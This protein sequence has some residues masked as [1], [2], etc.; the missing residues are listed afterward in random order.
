M[1]EDCL[2]ETPDPSTLA[3]NIM[4]WSFLRVGRNKNVVFD[5]IEWTNPDSPG[6]Y[7]AYTL[8]RLDSALGD[9]TVA[10]VGIQDSDVP[11]LA[12]CS[13]L[14]YYEQRAVETMDPAPIA[15]YLHELA[16]KITSFYHAERIQGGRPGRQ[17][18]MRN[19]HATMIR[20]FYLLGLRPLTR[21]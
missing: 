14:D 4:A 19:A 13:Y 3:W 8:A 16:I 6:L 20:A 15:N 12:A 18:A 5:P 17:F 7:A 1:V 9:L 2:K 10:S 11:L 21:V